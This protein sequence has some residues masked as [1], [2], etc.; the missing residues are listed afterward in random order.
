M[1][2]P[3]ELIETGGEV[4]AEY[5]PSRNEVNILSNYSSRLH[6]YLND[7]MLDLDAPVTIKYQGATIAKKTFQRSL[8]VI[9]Q[10]LPA[11]GDPHLAFSCVLTV[12]D[13]KRLEE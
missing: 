11:K 6:I 7:Q 12:I 9:Y 3:E 1:G 2:I 5:N 8:P 10:T 4:I 13:N